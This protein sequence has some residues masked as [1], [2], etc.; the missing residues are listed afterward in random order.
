MNKSWHWA[1]LGLVLVVVFYLK[2]YGANFTPREF[3]ASTT[4]IDVS[5][6]ALKISGGLYG[7]AYVGVI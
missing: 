1:F 4:G 2:N 3:T 7:L 5:E 6:D